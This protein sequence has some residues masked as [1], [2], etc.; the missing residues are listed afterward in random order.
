MQG[1]K[2]E[3]PLPAEHVLWLDSFGLPAGWQHADDI[4]RDPVTVVS[5][6]LVLAEDEQAITLAAHVGYSSSA[7]RPLF[8]WAARSRRSRCPTKRH[9]G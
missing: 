8:Q 1:T 2:S 6:G 4:D 5:T 3:T 9:A 7:S